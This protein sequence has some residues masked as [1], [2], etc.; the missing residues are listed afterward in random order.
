[1]SKRYICKNKFHVC[2]HILDVYENHRRK[3]YINPSCSKHP[4]FHLFEV[5]KRSVKMKNLCHFSPLLHW[6]NNAISVSLT[7]EIHKNYTYIYGV[8]LRV[9][10]KQYY[11]IYFSKSFIFIK[12]NWHLLS[13]CQILQ[14][15]CTRQYFVLSQMWTY[16]KSLLTVTSTNNTFRTALDFKKLK[17]MWCWYIHISIFIFWHDYKPQLFSNKTFQTNLDTYQAI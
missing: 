10:N 13:Y 14:E 9:T 17:I 8:T 16:S 11:Y 7:K 15:N 4:K 2:Y 1:M 12:R 6:D 3:N 5:P